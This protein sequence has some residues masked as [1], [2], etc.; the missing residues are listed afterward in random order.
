ME[1]L[2]KIQ[3]DKERA[4]S[5]VKLARLR[6][7][8]IKTFDIEKESSL[9][10]EGLY[11]VAKELITAILFVDGYKTLSHKDLIEYLRLNFKS[12]FSDLDANLLDQLRKLRNSIVY[13]GVFIEPSYV[14]R[15]SGYIQRIISK[16]FEV[17][18][19]KLK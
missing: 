5:L 18:E 12:D 4:R 2:T 11:E 13:Y 19:K 16:L 7:K 8:K 17:C 6:Y 1:N 10:V 3:P 15:N 9:I 14:K